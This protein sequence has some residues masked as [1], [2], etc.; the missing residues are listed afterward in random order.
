MNMTTY[1]FKEFEGLFIVYEVF[2]RSFAASEWTKLFKVNINT[3]KMKNLLQGNFVGKMIAE[4]LKESSNWFFDC[5]QKKGLFYAY[6]FENSDKHMPLYFVEEGF[7]HANIF[8][9]G[10]LQQNRKKSLKNV[11]SL[12]IHG[13]L[14]KN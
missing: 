7:W 3:C 5:P 14:V 4:S 6:N 13:S 1:F 10:V 9:K 11:M 2:G 12:L 8:V